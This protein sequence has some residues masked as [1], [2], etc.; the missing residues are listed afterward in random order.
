MSLRKHGSDYLVMVLLL[1]AGSLTVMLPVLKFTEHHESREEHELHE[2]HEH[3]EHKENARKS[4]AERYS[5]IFHMLRDPKTG[6][7]PDNARSRELSYAHMIDR[8]NR[9][10]KSSSTVAAATGFSWSQVGPYD[11]GGRTRA[12]AVDI[13]DPGTYLA[14]AVSGGVWKS[15]DFGADWTLTTS[16]DQSMSVTYLAQ[17]PVNTNIW[18]YCGGEYA[19]NTASTTGAPYMGAGIFKSTDNGDSWSVI[20][21]TQVTDETSWN[22]PF[23]LCSKIVVSPTTESVFVC[24]N[25]GVIMRMKKGETSF[26]TILGGLNEHYFTSIAVASNGTL[27]AA[28][29]EFHYSGQPQ[30]SDPGIY[31]STDDGDTWTNITPKPFP[32]SY[33]RTVLDFAPSDPDIAYS[34]TYTGKEKDGHDDM[35]FFKY[36]VSGDSASA[37]DRSANLPDFGGKAG[38][39]HQGNYNM[40]IAVKPDD[41]DFVLIGSTNLYRSF[42]G[43]ATP[44][45]NL[46]KNW[47]G[48]YSTQNNYESYPGHHPDQHVIAFTPGHPDIVLSGHDGGISETRDITQTSGT[49]NDVVDWQSLDNKYLTTQFYAV[50]MRNVKGDTRI[51]GG[52]QDNG[53]PFFEAGSDLNSVSVD[54]SSGDG[55]DAYLGAKY[56]YAS[57]QNGTVIRYNYSRSGQIN[58]GSQREVQPVEATSPLFINPYAVDPGNENV[59]LYPSGD[60]LW[61]NTKMESSDPGSSWQLVTKVKGPTGENFTAVSISQ[62]PEHIAYLGTSGGDSD[63]P[64]V[65]RMDNA[66]TSAD[67]ADISSSAFP[68]GGYITDIA[69]NPR[70]ANEFIVVFSNYNV[71]SLFYSDDGGK[72]YS[73]IEGNLQGQLEP[74]SGDYLG[75]SVRSAAITYTGDGKYFLAGTSTGL[76]MTTKLA[77]DNTQWVKQA[78]GKDMIGETVVD[79]LYAR[80]VDGWI[81]VGTHGRGVFLGRPNTPL[82]IEKNPAAEVPVRFNL[83][84]NYPNPFNPSTNIPFELHQPA[85]VTLRVYDITGRLVSTLLDDEYRGA[86]QYSIRFA[87]YQLASGT[88]FYRLKALTKDGRFV[89]TRKMTL[90]R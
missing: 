70:D 39:F 45:D 37:V 30:N 36:T 38:S 86:G 35:R 24:T 19:G 33:E 55:G 31:L 41:P 14:G 8:E 40:L 56:A 77:G 28:L 54:I 67:A 66:A 61:R 72:T 10:S 32:I 52:T 79:Y 12:L 4:G 44:A 73:Q 17:D 90:L 47:I 6:K 89:R 53:S 88:Y 5:Y 69:V 57:V 25:A 59:M 18:Y 64:H 87:A 26:K 29:S 16:S 81:A 51:L 48:G 20:P 3:E 2:E 60:S 1:I 43:F 74:A 11:V 84:Q 22:S 49:T 34:F 71:P 82:A 78:S 9:G 85:R 83:E 68:T 27:M 63:N 7:I 58:L 42:D 50:T 15:T 46:R 23:Q 76:Y 75:P 13:K 65:Y 62:E 80:P 21:S